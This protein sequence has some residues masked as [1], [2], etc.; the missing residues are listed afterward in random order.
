MILLILEF[1]FIYDRV[2]GP[3]VRCSESI[4]ALMGSAPG[5]QLVIA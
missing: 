4:N 3:G 5:N 2:D 1:P